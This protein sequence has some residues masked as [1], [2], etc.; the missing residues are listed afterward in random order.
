MNEI[1][2]RCQNT[3]ANNMELKKRVIFGTHFTMYINTMYLDR[4]RAEITTSIKE[5]FDI[6]ILMH[7][8]HLAV[9]LN[10]GKIKIVSMSSLF[11]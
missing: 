8:C 11:S 10:E 5:F 3:R 2:S 9:V 1:L 4:H 7:T 6:T